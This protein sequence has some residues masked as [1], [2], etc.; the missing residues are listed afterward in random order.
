[1]QRN[2]GRATG[3]IYA[4]IKAGLIF[5]PLMSEKVFIDRIIVLHKIIYKTF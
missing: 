4:Q 3:L 5:V 1:M 2:S